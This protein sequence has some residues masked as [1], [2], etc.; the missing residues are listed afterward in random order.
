MNRGTISK[1]FGERKGSH[2]ELRHYARQQGLQIN[3][4]DF[5]LLGHANQFESGPG[6]CSH[7]SIARIPDRKKFR[8]S[9]VERAI[10]NP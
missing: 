8:G 9:S 4:R 6:D 3:R 5:D 7:L 1:R 2:G 10:G